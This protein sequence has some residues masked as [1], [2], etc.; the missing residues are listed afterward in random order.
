MT[1]EV[2][3]AA[4]RLINSQ[5]NLAHA[6]AAGGLPLVIKQVHQQLSQLV[7]PLAQDL[8]SDQKTRDI[9]LFKAT[10]WN[11]LF[12][13]NLYSSPFSSVLFLWSVSFSTT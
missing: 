11:V 3:Q 5:L 1:G 6:Q 13:I 2:C 10:Q 8:V 7:E 9:A 4:P 12:Q